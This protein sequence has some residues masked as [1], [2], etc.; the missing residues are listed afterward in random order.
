MKDRDVPTEGRLLEELA[1]R[2]R[3][4]IAAEHRREWSRLWTLLRSLE[5][6]AGRELPR[7]LS[8]PTFAPDV[9]TDNLIQAEISRIR[10][11]FLA[12]VGRISSEIW[13]TPGTGERIGFPG[14]DQTYRFCY[15]RSHTPDILERRIQAHDNNLGRPKHTILCGSGM[16]AI[17]TILQSLALLA[18][19]R[20]TKIGV[21]ASYFE[22][23]SLLRF[24]SFAGSWKRLTCADE[25]LEAVRNSDF[26]IIFVEPVQYDW[27][28]TTTPWTHFISAISDAKDP[29]I[30]VLD[31]TLSGQT[32]PVEAVL[33]ELAASSCPLLARVRSGLK[34]DQQGLELASVGVLEWWPRLEV[35][36]A[37]EKLAHLTETF[38]TVSGSGL[39][40]SAACA[41]SPA[42]ALDPQAG[43]EYAEGVYLS[44][45]SL[46]E[47]VDLSG[48]LFSLKVYP[49]PPWES[50]FVLFEL[51]HGGSDAY[52]RLASLLKREAHRRNLGWIMSGSFGFRTER[53]ETILPG[54][55]FRPGEASAGILKV[56]AGRYLGAR[57]WEIVDLL[58]ELARFDALEDA[59]S[60]W[61]V[62]VR[63]VQ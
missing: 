50:P 9:A 58:N 1:T 56:S 48:A 33:S 40:R 47:L 10:T 38:R 63:P 54:E 7:L 46:F 19:P 29:P 26:D 36:S 55:Q 52:A 5:E 57:F 32:L 6:A 13:L 39:Y 49:R 61:G 44:N 11:W 3:S 62:R 60:A 30:V 20:S 37:Y 34:L 22:T 28:L 12:E 25:L 8:T 16:A 18:R 51:T 27:R 53:F 41:L 21:F 59:E 14:T 23:H 24:S 42:F 45:R 15:D 43:N 17:N 2:E 31:T 35:Q 4:T